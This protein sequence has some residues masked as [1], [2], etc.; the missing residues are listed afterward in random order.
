MY[1]N[2]AKM[3]KSIMVILRVVQLF[4]VIYIVIFIFYWLLMMG[5]ATLAEAIEPFYILP[6]DISDMI[7]TSFNL[8]LYTNYPRLRMDIGASIF[9]SVAALLFSNFIFIPLW[10]LEKK[11][12]NKAYE[13]GEIKDNDI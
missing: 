4:W 9:F 7:L 2:Y 12:I 13:A 11:F 8:D 3:M 5:Q 6:L 1:K 10:A